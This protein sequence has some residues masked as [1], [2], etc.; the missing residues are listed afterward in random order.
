VAYQTAYLKAHYPNEY[1]AAVLTHNQ[2][3]IDKVSFFMEESKR[4]GIPVLGPDVNES[5]LDFSVNQKGQIRFGLSAIKGV[6]EQPSLS[7]IDERKKGGPFTSI[8]DLTKRVNLKNVNKRVLEPL[9]LSGGFDCFANTHRAQYFFTTNEVEPSPIEKA[10]KY[11]ANLQANEAGGQ[12]SLF[13][14]SNQVNLTEPQLPKCEPWP[15]LLELKKEKEVIGMYISGHP[16]DDFK[17]EI[18]HFCNSDIKSTKLTKNKD[19][20]LAAIVTKVDNRIDKQNRP[21][22]RVTIEDFD[23]TLEFAVFSKEYLQFEKFLVENR[24]LLIKGKMETRW[25]TSDQFEFKPLIIEQLGDIRGTKL[26]SVSLWMYLGQLTNSFNQKVKEVLEKFPGNC[27]LNFRVV[28]VK[29]NLTLDL[30]SKKYR[31]NPSDEFFKEIQDAGILSYA[32]NGSE[33]SPWEVEEAKLTVPI[34]L[35]DLEIFDNI[36]VESE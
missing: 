32:I 34:E 19:V 26:K 29:D 25:K 18:P 36:L 15:R 17:F 14:G 6:G 30:I 11:G 12:A 27:S 9:A 2:G 16:L 22:A 21:W 4:M 23:D 5:L 20:V 3:N 35:T 8:F 31:I 24:F 28:M 10:L 33:F 7:I 13:G 1:M